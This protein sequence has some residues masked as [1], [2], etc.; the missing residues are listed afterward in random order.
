MT[1][2]EFGML[3]IYAK[4]FKFFKVRLHNENKC[5]SSLSLANFSS[6]EI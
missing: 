6:S 1:E 4:A 3:A 2:I 5:D